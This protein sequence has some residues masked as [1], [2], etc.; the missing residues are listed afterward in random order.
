MAKRYSVESEPH[1]NQ[2]GKR[3]YET[4]SLDEAKMVAGIM[5]PDQHRHVYIMDWQT[6]QTMHFVI[7][8]EKVVGDLFWTK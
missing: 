4:D 1:K 3:E 8:G 2:M 6:Y 5:Q 7:D